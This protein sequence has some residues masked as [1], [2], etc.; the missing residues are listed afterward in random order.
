VEEKPQLMDIEML[1]LAMEAFNGAAANLQRSYDILKDEARRL[2]EEVEEKNIKLSYFS[3]LLESVMN[4]TPSAI[5]VVNERQ[6]FAVKNRAAEAL[7]AELG[8]SAL[9]EM[10]AGSLGQKVFDCNSG[11]RWY[12]L[13][14]GELN[15]EELRGTVYVIDEI[16]LLKK[17]EKEKQRG[18]QLQTMGEMAANIA[19]EIRNP[20]GSIELFASLLERD[21]A[22]NEAAVKMT[23]NIVKAVRT[24]NGII[25][26]TLLFTKELNID[27]K[28]YVLSDIVD[29]VI[30]YLQPLLR[31]KEVSVLNRLD[32][33]HAVLCE[34]GLFYQAVMNIVHNAI[35]A[36]PA[37]SGKVEIISGKDAVF[38]YSLRLSVTD[39][40]GGI[41]PSMRDKLFLP[42]QTTKANGSG[43]GLSIAYKIIKAHGGDIIADSDGVSYT[44]FTVI[45]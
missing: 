26:N 45:L 5:L 39:N 36:A 42:F 14:A 10:L 18:I 11:S 32:E 20:L 13:S 34:R 19:H 40:G 31:E 4:N 29:D 41:V 37:K 17:F 1:N 22:G 38:P 30:L 24:M 35:D 27:K 43:L 8:E 25:S 44:K 6:E 28:E 23:S 33:S 15:S 9:K 3:N 7:V 16:T 12:R 21:L 2:R